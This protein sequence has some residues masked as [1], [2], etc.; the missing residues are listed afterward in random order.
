MAIAK[1]NNQSHK[2]HLE[3]CH[4]LLWQYMMN[5]KIPIDV[6]TLI[7]SKSVFYENTQLKK[8]LRNKISDIINY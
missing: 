7:W 2:P 1:R 4:D 3:V 6:K 5:L 8:M